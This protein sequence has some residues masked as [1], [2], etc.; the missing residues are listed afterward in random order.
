VFCSCFA[1]ANAAAP[2]LARN[3]A[4]H[5]EH[6]TMLDNEVGRLG[7]TL[8]LGVAWRGVVWRGL[9]HARVFFEHASETD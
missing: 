9:L 2:L 4:N 3:L 5:N 1:Q 8:R 7:L 6:G